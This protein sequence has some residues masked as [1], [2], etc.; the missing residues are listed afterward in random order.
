MKPNLASSLVED[1]R[2]RISSGD[3][4]AGEKLPSENTLIASHGVSRTVVR[5][6][7]TRLQAEGL[8]YTRR[9]AG[10]FALT[11]PPETPTESQSLIP[12]TLEER[13]RLIEFRLGFETEAAANAALKSSEQDLASMDAA[14]QGF[15]ASLGNASV[16]MRCDY[17]F[18]LAV[19]RATGNSYFIQAVQNFGPAMIAMPRRRLDSSESI[20]STRLD[21]VAA[22]HRAI[23]QA[24]ASA[25]PQLASAAMRIHLS[26]S[27]ARLQAEA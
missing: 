10:S 3:I 18:H 6:A 23:H 24:I 7:I 15:E 17:E 2:E 25:N 8:I 22:E 4:A 13:R 19:A 26:N 5:E 11:P 9:G 21:S 1:L 20:D 27:M 14:L 12:R 16:S